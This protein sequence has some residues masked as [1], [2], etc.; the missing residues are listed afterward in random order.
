LP[1]TPSFPQFARAVPLRPTASKNSPA[2]L[3]MV[4]FIVSELYQNDAINRSHKN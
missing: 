4:I 3:I 1:F 2:I